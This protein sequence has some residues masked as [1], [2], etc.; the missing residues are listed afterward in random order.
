MSYEIVRSLI[1]V[2]V[3]VLAY[4]CGEDMNPKD[5]PSTWHKVEVFR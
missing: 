1:V 4:L 2:F 5:K 3:F